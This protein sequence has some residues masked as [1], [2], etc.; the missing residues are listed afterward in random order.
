M[1]QSGDGGQGI[2]WRGRTDESRME[3]RRGEMVLRGSRGWSSGERN[4]ARGAGEVEP[5]RRRGAGPREA[6]QQPQG[7]KSQQARPKGQAGWPTGRPTDEP[8]LAS[9][10]TP[11]PSPCARPDRRSHARTPDSDPKTARGV[12]V[13]GLARGALPAARAPSFG[14]DPQHG[15]R[16]AIGIGPPCR[17]QCVGLRSVSRGLSSGWLAS[18][19]RT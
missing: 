10:P 5:R 15:G 12:G 7:P 13:G 16:L 17:R 4:T 1:G 9:L 6:A 14:A 19:W 18:L 11:R 3:E 8:L 2:V